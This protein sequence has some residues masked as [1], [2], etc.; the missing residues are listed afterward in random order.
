MVKL[1]REMHSIEGA[2]IGSTGADARPPAVNERAFGNM[3]RVM[4]DHRVDTEKRISRLVEPLTAHFA[5][6]PSIPIARVI[7]QA[8]LGNPCGYHELVVRVNDFFAPE[9]ESL[10]DQPDA[11][12]QTGH[13]S[14][15]AGQANVWK[16]V[17]YWLRAAVSLVTCSKSRL[18]ACHVC[19]KIVDVQISVL[20]V[21]GR[22]LGVSL[23]RDIG[24]FLDQ[25][26]WEHI[27]ART[28]HIFATA[29]YARDQYRLLTTHAA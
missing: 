10:Q 17:A 6:Y 26:Q 23:A 9:D 21:V 4:A 29:K 7:C 1:E 5:R 24:E 25:P 2:A 13:P 19:R 14:S 18:P 12:F 15:I 22:M 11:L 8:G 3:N 27:L 20:D 16:L 28:L